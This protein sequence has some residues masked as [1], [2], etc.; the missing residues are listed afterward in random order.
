[1]KQVIKFNELKQ[2]GLH[3]IWK[4]LK[5]TDYEKFYY[6]QKAAENGCKVAQFNLGKYYEL[7]KGV[8]KDERIAFELYEKSAKQGYIIQMELE[9]ILIKKR[10]LNYIL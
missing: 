3:Y 7:E 10:H 8:E 1:M 5:K 2:F 9:L 4:I 6:H